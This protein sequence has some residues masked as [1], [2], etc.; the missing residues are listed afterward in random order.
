MPYSAFVLIPLL[1]PSY[2]TF[3]QLISP[4]NWRFLR[5]FSF[6]AP[7][8]TTTSLTTL[9]LLLFPWFQGKLQFIN[10]HLG[11]RARKQIKKHRPFTFLFLGYFPQYNILNKER[12][13]IIRRSFRP[14][15]R[16]SFCI[17]EMS[18]HRGRIVRMKLDWILSFVILLWQ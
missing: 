9:G 3:L 17:L 18:T 1:P 13:I 14:P 5:I 4:G 7:F 8:S 2:H 10:T 16:E 6:N 12:K 15:L 11:V